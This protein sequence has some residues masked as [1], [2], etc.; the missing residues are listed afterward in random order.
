MAY[1]LDLIERTKVGPLVPVKVRMGWQ[2]YT[3]RSLAAI[4]IATLLAGVTMPEAVMAGYRWLVNVIEEF[5][6]DRTEY[7]YTS[8]IDEDVEFVPLTF[9]Y[10]PEGMEIKYQNTKN[11]RIKILYSN[12]TTQMYFEYEQKRLN[13]HWKR[14][15]GTNVEI[16]YTDTYLINDIKLKLID[17]ND[18]IHFT[19]VS[20][21]Y[22]VNGQ[23]NYP[24]DEFLK[25]MSEI[26][27][28]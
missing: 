26:S 7:R 16:Y 17:R 8:D 1:M 28:N 23:S 25:I 10:I 2:Y 6:E 27:L 3:R 5:F 21:M 15:Y 18:I 4:L 14:V 24:K 22:H 13:E 12:E 9:G 19:F 20:D 11:D